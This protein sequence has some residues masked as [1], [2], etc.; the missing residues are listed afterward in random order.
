[1]EINDWKSV[2]GMGVVYRKARDMGLE[3]NIAELE[4]FGFTVIPPEQS[5]VSLE[6]VNRLLERLDEA[7]RRQD[8][9]DAGLNDDDGGR[10]AAG[11]QIF[12]LLN[13]DQI[14]IEL[15]MH[16]ITRTLASYMVGQSYR[17]NFISAVLKKGT[18]RP[19]PMHC[20]SVGVPTPL[21]ASGAVCNISWILTDY[22]P[23]TGTLGM[24]PGSH[25]FCRHPTEGEQPQF[26]DGQMDDA[27]VAPVMAAPGSIVA[28]TG[29]TW[30]C[31]YPKTDEGLRAHIATT[32]CRN[33]VLP[34]ESYDDLSDE[35]VDAQDAEF[36]RLIGRTRWQG[37][38]P[39]PPQLEYLPLVVPAYQTQ[40]G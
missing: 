26:A 17:L 24:V 31:T 2:A 35:I 36:A 39:N 15:M 27:M 29:N 19:T 28:F 6:F 20:D 5:G 30:H 40:Y 16:P 9:T 38:G 33:Y 18:A 11:R 21:P 37:R 25:R 3:P 4:A 8:P 10:P 7:G 23:E 1:M 22:T 14:F 34:G 32:F 13:E 12:Q